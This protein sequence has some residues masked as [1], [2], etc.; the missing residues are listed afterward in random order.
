VIG[1]G[2]IICVEFICKFVLS[3]FESSSRILICESKLEFNSCCCLSD[4][5]DLSKIE[6][7]LKSSSL[8]SKRFPTLFLSLFEFSW[9]IDDFISICCLNVLCRGFINDDTDW[10]G[11]VEFGDVGSSLDFLGRWI[12][13]DKKSF[14]LFISSDLL[15]LN[16]CSI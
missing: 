6:S 9:M 8:R 1:D 14:L 7:L 2:K 5:N 11:L 4:E 13:E 12:T 3:E 16:C 10:C 15:V